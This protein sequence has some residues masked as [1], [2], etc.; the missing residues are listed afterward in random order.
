MDA[1]WQWSDSSAVQIMWVLVGVV[2]LLFCLWLKERS[3]KKWGEQ[4]ARLQEAVHNANVINSNFFHS[5]E[6]VQKHL[7]S[8]LVR[9]DTA[10]Q[11]LRRLLTQ[12]EVGRVDQYATASLLLSEGE[13]VEQV[14]RVLR[15]PLT[16]VR[17]VQELRQEVD[18][19]RQ[20]GGGDKETKKISG[21]SR[22][23]G[24]KKKLHPLAAHAIGDGGA[25]S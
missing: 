5:L 20:Q 19:K 24:D 3:R 23:K 11:R 9:A 12:A 13:E 2:G 6:V 7:E 16:Q 18:K 25:P 14:A 4:A 22:T 10:E 17:L 8:L 21:D 15:L 1:F